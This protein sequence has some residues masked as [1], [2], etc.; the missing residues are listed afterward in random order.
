MYYRLGVLS[1]KYKIKIVYNL[2]HLRVS[3]SDMLLDI[4]TEMSVTNNIV[5]D[6]KLYSVQHNIILSGI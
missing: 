6:T 4:S 3:H 2:F 5:T 1:M